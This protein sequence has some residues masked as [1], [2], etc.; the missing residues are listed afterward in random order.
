MKWHGS[1]GLGRAEG[2]SLKILCPCAGDYKGKSDDHPLTTGFTLETYFNIFV[3]E[4]N[5]SLYFVSVKIYSAVLA[6]QSW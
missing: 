6:G 2:A 4:S 1:S 5:S 3:A